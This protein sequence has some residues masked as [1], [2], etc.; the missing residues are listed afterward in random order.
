MSL[1]YEIKHFA[2]LQEMFVHCDQRVVFN[3]CFFLI[4]IMRQVV[5]VTVSKPQQTILPQE[6]TQL[7]IPALVSLN[8][9]LFVAEL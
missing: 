5:S 9:F 4:Q 2:E 1:E 7:F 8:S 3:F 6:K